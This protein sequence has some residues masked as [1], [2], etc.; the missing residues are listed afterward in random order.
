MSA[1]LLWIIVPAAFA[2]A[3]LLISNQRTLTIA[4][5]SLA[6]LLAFTALIIPIDQALQIGNFSFK[7]TP[8][9]QILGRSPR[10]VAPDGAG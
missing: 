8:A 6:L 4:G 3:S 9:I 5:G 2:A 1:P 10:G 7:I